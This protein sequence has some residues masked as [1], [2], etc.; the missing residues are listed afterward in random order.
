MGGVPRRGIDVEAELV[1]AI[2]DPVIGYDTEGTIVYW[3]RAAEATYGYSADEAVGR[4]AAAVLHTRFPAPQLEIVE[5]FMDLGHW[6]GRLVHQAR[7]GRTIEVESRWVA[8][9]DEAG[10]HAGGFAIERELPPVPPLPPAPPGPPAPPTPPPAQPHAPALAATD[11][12]RLAS[13]VG[14]V[15]RTAHDLNNALAIVINYSAFIAT[16]FEELTQAAAGPARDTMRADL[17]EVQIAA[18]HALRLTREML[19]DTHPPAAPPA[20][21]DRG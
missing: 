11:A 14:L 20:A 18:E 3:S 12:D 21:G 5:E 6:E 4:R 15:G 16:E 13:L 2:P 9:Y 7:D 17:R 1:E 10:A 8:R 19:T